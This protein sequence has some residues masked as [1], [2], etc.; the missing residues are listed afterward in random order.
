MKLHTFPPAPNPRKLN[1]YLREKG[2]E[3]PT[4]WV[5]LLKGEHK[6]PEFLAM[7]PAGN[8]PVLELDDGTVLTESL[9]IIE[10]LEELHPDPPMIGTTALERAQTRRIERICEMGV[11]GRVARIVH[12]SNSPLPGVQG[13]TAIADHFREELE[14]VLARL[15]AEIGDRPFVAGDRPTIADCTLFGALEFGRFGGVEPGPQYANIH[16]WWADFAKRPSA[17]IAPP[18]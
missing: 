18:G 17:E 8:L 16:R 4:V 9:A 7:N 14:P 12:N 10:Y 5:N 13:K 3:I 6:T 15:D 11:L 2:I 1:T